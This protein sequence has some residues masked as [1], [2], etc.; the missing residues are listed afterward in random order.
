MP[1]VTKLVRDNVPDLMRADGQD[2]QVRIATVQ[3]M[4]QRFELKMI[5]E[6]TEA[7]ENPCAEEYGDIL[8]AMYERAAM[9]GISPKDIEEARL[10]KFERKGG[11]SKRL[12]A[13]FTKG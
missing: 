8:Q 9:V 4:P 12:I 10:K 13:S 7:A 5:E 3:E 11:Y 2:V 6:F 1:V